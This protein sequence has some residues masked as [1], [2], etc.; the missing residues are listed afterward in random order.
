LWTFS[1]R[2]KSDTFSTH[3]NFFACVHTQFGVTIQGIQCDNGLEFDNLNARTF[4]SSHGVHLRMSCP[5]T[6]NK[7]SKDERILRSINNAIRSMLIQACFPPRFGVAAL[8]TTTYLLNTLPIK[9]LA[10]STPHL[11]LFGQPPSYEHLRVFGCACYPN[12]SATAPH[13]LSPRSTL[14]V[15]LGYSPHHKGYLCFN[16]QSNRIIISC[17]VSFDETSF[18]FF[19]DS[20]PTRATFDFLDDTTNPVIVPFGLPL[21]SIFFRYHSRVFIRS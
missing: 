13:K 6:S 4:F 9:T 21:V 8:G 2:L 19:E 3:T 15:F 16:R 1:L 20:S 11:A 7:N 12:L 18:P 5:H 10:F 14:C 17:H